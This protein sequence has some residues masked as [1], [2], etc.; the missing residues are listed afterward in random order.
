VTIDVLP[1]DVL[2]D[3][4]TFYVNI[5]DFSWDSPRNTWHALVHVCRRWRYLVFASPRRLNL[6]L[7]YGGHGP[8]S[9]VLDAWPVLPVM[10]ISGLAD[11]YQRWCNWVAALESEHYHR[12]CEI[13]ISGMTHLRWGGFIAAMKKPFPELTH[14]EV[15]VYVYRFV[16]PVLPD[17]FL[18]GSAPRLRELTLR[19]TPFPSI[20]KLLLSANGLVKLTLLDIPDSGYISPDAM[21][22]ALTVMTRLKTLDLQFRSP[23]SLSDSTSRPLPPPTRFVLP[24]LTELRF[25][26]VYEYLEDLLARIDAPFLYHLH[27]IFFTNP[28][29]DFPQLRRLISNAGDFKEFDHGGVLILH[30]SIQLSLYPKTEEV[31]HR[32]LLKLQIDCGGLDRQLSSLAHVCSSSLPL[33]GISTLEVLEIREYD[34]ITSLFW[35][36][37]MDNA[38]WMELLDQFTALKNLYLTR[39]VTHRVFRALQGLSGERATEVLPALRNLFVRTP[40]LEP[41]QE[42][43]RS[44]VAARRLSGRPVAIDH[45]RI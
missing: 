16:E 44:F 36:D 26:G 8:M 22:T 25:R 24:A 2:V 38:Q 20:P 14:L 17:S 15:S 19:S 28:N 5:D 31:N 13:R 33:T 40:S 3:I 7:A 37:D 18:G 45:W 11:S 41:A 32:T 10:L 9:E 21:A 43:I 27:I 29:L 4:F 42:A 34:Y 6:R 35:K 23:R 1:D 30:S 12:I 39:G